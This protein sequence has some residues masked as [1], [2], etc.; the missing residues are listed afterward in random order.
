M[1]RLVPAVAAL[2]LTG[3]SKQAA[4]KAYMIAELTITDAA[5]FQ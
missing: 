1:Q 4:S 2:M 3:A 5:A